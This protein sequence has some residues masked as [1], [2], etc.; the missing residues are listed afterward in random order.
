MQAK[1]FIC[2]SLGLLAT[3]Q[4]ASDLATDVRRCSGN[5]P[6]PLEVRVGGCITPPCN[7]VK[8]ST[9]LFEIDFAVDK[10]ITSMKAMV[11]ATT[12]GIITVPYELPPEVAAVCP[13]LMYGAYC[14]LYPTEDVT[15][16]FS[17]PIGEY[18]EIG[19]K[20]EIYLVD[21]DGD[22]STCFVCDIKV[23]KGNGSS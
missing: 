8:G 5:K 21:Q 11:K 23:V 16:L 15:Y 17:F 19:V 1:A 22:T 12:L 3:V 7:V 14:P 6:F 4:A 18:P 20:V 2:I 13:N 10:Y 9:Q